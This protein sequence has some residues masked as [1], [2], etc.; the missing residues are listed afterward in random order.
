MR[1]GKLI[2][3]FYFEKYSILTKKIQQKK[4]FWETC[5]LNIY[6]TKFY[7]L[8]V[9]KR[10]SKSFFF[11]HF[12]DQTEE[13]RTYRL[14]V[15]K[16]FSKSFFLGTFFDQ[17]EE[18]WTY[19]LHGIGRQN[20]KKK[21]FWPLELTDLYLRFNVKKESFGCSCSSMTK[22][23]SERFFLLNQASK[24]RNPFF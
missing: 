13:I 19:R 8:H 15:F 12:F 7:K 20:I 22:P 2:I 14:H 1:L 6:Q 18:I 3:H 4:T 23:K 10:F 17:T 16:C 21:L 5:C 24:V 9:L 11:L